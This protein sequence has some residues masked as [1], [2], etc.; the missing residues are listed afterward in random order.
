MKTMKKIL[1]SGLIL[2]FWVSGFAQ[3]K[4]VRSATGKY[5]FVNIFGD[6]V[7]PA[8]YDYAEDFSEGLALVKK[9]KGYKL[10]DTLGNLWD[11]SK[12][13]KTPGLRYDWGVYHSGMP[14]LL[15]VWD[16]A[17]IDQNGKIALK[18]P[19]RDA[20]SFRNSK[21]KVWEGDKYAYIN[22]YGALVTPWKE[23][24]DNYR[25][26]KY[27]GFYG[28]VNKNGKL[29]IDYQ[30]RKAYDFKDG[31]A[32][33]SPDMLRWAIINKK[34][35]YISDFYDEISDFDGSVAIVKKEGS[36]GFIG[37]DGKFRSGWYEEVQKM[38][39]ALYRVKKS[40][41]YALVKDGFQ[42]TKW[43]D[44]IERYDENYWLA[45]DGDKYAF[46]NNMGAYVVGWYHKLWTLPGYPD[47]VFVMLDNKYGF[48]NVH[49]YYISPLFDTL[50][51][52]EGI[53]LVRQDGK[54]GF[55]SMTGKKIT[56]IDYD[57]ATPFKNAVATVE[58][59][60]KVAYINPEGKLI[61]DWIDKDVI[62]KSPPPG[63]FV[64]KIGN[65]YG[66]QT[67][68]GRRVIPAEYDYAEPFSEGVALVKL[69][70]KWMYIDTT[71][72]LLPIKNNKDNPAL[73]LDWGY[74]HTLKPIK[75]KVWDYLAY[76]NP[77]GKV[78]LKLPPEITDAESFRNGR[79]K[80][81]KGDKYNYIDKKGNLLYE[82]KDIP[83]DY[84]VA[85]RNGKFG[86]ID[87]NNHLVIEPKFDYAY[88][89]KN[90][91]AKVQ[92]N[93]KWGYINREGK[94]ITPL[95]DNISDFENGLAIAENNGKYALVSRSGKVISQWYDKIYPFRDGMAKVRI[96]D[97]YSFVNT[98]GKQIPLTFDE[99]ED[100]SEGLAKVRV[101]DKWG[102]IN[103]DGKFIVKPQ[104][105]WATSF[106]GG[107]AKVQK[108]DKYTLIG[109]K[110]Q[111]ITDW[112]DRIYFF[113]DERAVVMKDGKWGY[114]DVNGR[115]VIPLIYDKAYAFSNGKAMAIKDGKIFI[116]D[117]NGDILE[118]KEIAK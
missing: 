57:Y 109:T 100:F 78:V 46:L 104:Y 50:V 66:Y 68:N 53:A 106:T 23:E 32:K 9:L 18:I 72:K 13:G 25:A 24:P 69:Y 60:G 95:F 113:S 62:V 2:M 39:S 75:I 41:S 34:G 71:G 30:F 102:F 83:D 87:K 22:R 77:E 19:Y 58:K 35:K 74:R 96:G 81:Y 116:I 93:G 108:G 84:H 7:V 38:D 36:Y 54:Y 28:Y 97:K 27:K 51:F 5:G 64:V 12:F 73:R 117:H 112:F 88:D 110:G 101:G 118:E 111:Q 8:I 114:I 21:A 17:Y 63:L 76:I 70:P 105:D 92:L 33:V 1:L 82:W 89:F 3:L 48:Y 37:I 67:L 107:M 31:I 6:T 15:P 49:N 40:E 43:Y 29:V 86:F 91:V 56:S 80:V 98:K 42:V 11:L 85:L 44:N 52:S 4:L 59:D 16:C 90:G 103:K 61:M 26:V 47:L 20:T 65:K 99:A 94:L 45:K 55:I 10:I 14:L 115:I 79:A